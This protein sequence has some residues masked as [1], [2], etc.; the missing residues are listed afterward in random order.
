MPKSRNNAGPQ[1]REGSSSEIIEY[2]DGSEMKEAYRW[3]GLRT[4]IDRKDLDRIGT[5]P[6]AKEKLLETRCRK[7]TCRKKYIPKVKGQFLCDDHWDFSR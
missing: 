7:R 4:Y 6:I 3:K 1:P 2:I 5:I